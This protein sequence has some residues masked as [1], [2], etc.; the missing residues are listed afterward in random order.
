MTFDIKLHITFECKAAISFSRM[1]QVTIITLYNHVLDS[2]F[3]FIE[4]DIYYISTLNNTL[5]KTNV[6]NSS[7]GIYELLNINK[8]CARFSR[9]RALYYP[10][11]VSK[12]KFDDKIS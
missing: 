1:V 11:P 9:V 3:Y 12:F 8:N 2:Y 5:N 7:C 6:L 10:P 4:V